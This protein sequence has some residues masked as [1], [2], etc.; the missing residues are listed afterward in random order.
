MLYPVLVLATLTYDGPRICAKF[1]TAVGALITS[2]CGL[3]VMRSA[4][5][6]T[7]QQYLIVIFSALLFEFDYQSYSETFLIDY[8]FMGIIF[9]KTY[10]FILKVII[11]NERLKLTTGYILFYF[12]WKNKKDLLIQFFFSGSIC[13]NVYRSLA[14]N[15][16]F[17]FSRICPTVLSPAFSYAFHSSCYIGRFVGSFKSVFRYE[18]IV[19]LYLVSFFFNN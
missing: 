8:F 3:K 17:S 7:S 9:A 13:N 12:F 11:L 19:K 15:L 10:E 16:G 14:N 18:I 2:V 6:N 5:S 1:G 4:F